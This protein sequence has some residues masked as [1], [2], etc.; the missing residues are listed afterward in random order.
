MLKTITLGSCVFVQGIFLRVLND[1]RVAVRVDDRIFE[2]Y[3]VEKQA[4]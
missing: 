4:A 2:G 1:G 3:P